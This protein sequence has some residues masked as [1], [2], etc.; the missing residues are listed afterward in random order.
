MWQQN[1]HI[2]PQKTNNLLYY[3]IELGNV[4]KTVYFTNPPSP[5]PQVVN[6]HPPEVLPL[7]CRRVPSEVFG[8]SRRRPGI[9]ASEM[10]GSPSSLHPHQAVEVIG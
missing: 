10:C 9:S 7:G 5:P 8:Y 3:S 6:F 4:H 2:P 1:I